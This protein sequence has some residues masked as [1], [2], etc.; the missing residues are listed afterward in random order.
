[1]EN[2][3]ENVVFKLPPRF[4]IGYR[5]V[6]VSHTNHECGTALEAVLFDGEDVIDCELYHLPSNITSAKAAM[7]WRGAREAEYEMELMKYLFDDEGVFVHGP[8]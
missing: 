1:M 4:V 3:N 7:R 8:H 5:I 6:D 2:G